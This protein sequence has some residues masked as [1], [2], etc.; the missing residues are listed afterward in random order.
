MEYIK[1]ALETIIKEYLLPNK[2]VI[3]LGAR[4]VGKT[5]LIKHLLTNTI[6]KTMVLNGED[7]DVQLALHDRSVRNYKQFLMNTQLLVIDEAQA[8]PDIGLKLK[9]MIDSIAGL[10]ILVTGSSVFDLDN[11]LGEPLVGRSYTFKL[12]PIAQMELSERENFMETKGRLD[13]RLIYGSYPELL[14]LE[15]YA[16]KE[17]YLKEQVNSYLLKDILAFE[18]VRKQTKI[19]SLLRLIAFRVGSEISIE[20]IGKDLDLNKSTVDRYLDLLSKVFIIY[21]IRGFSRNLGNEITKKSKWYFYDNG[22]RNALINNF[23]PM[24]LRDD[25]GKLWENYIISERLKFQEYSKMHAAN[26]FWRTHTQQEI[27]WIEDRGGRLHA[28]EVKWGTNK[29]S[30]KPPLW[31]KTYPDASFEIVNPKNYLAFI[32]PQLE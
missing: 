19:V 30:T 31:G 16:K 15:K 2:V 7:Q 17:K 5:E 4:R 11:Q 24:T 22:I 9:L 10:K 3:I 32:T 21:N 25:H 27:D 1:R 13:E 12:F 23:N 29:K 14:Q 8:I 20:S 28:Y 18:G 6:E 26:F